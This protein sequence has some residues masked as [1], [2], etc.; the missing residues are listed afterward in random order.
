MHQLRTFGG[1]DLRDAEGREVQALLAQPKR[2]ALLVYLA[3]APA[4]NRYRRR[5]T[6]LALFWPEADTEHARASLRQALHY[7]RRSLGDQVLLGRSDEEIGID[8]NGLQCDAALLAEASRAGEWQRASALYAG[9]FL[10]GFHV[11]GAA[12]ELDEWI[13][14]ERSRLR[15]IACDA[16][17]ALAD[18]ALRVGD[19]PAA[20]RWGREG[21]RLAADPDIVAERFLRLT[22]SAQSQ[23]AA[24]VEAAVLPPQEAPAQSPDS[25]V[26]HDTGRTR[27]R[28]I[29]RAAAAMVVLV[30][31]ALVGTRVLRPPTVDS[32][33]TPPTGATIPPVKATEDTAPDAVRR[34]LP[35]DHEAHLLVLRGA[36]ALAQRTRSDFL[37]ARDFYLRA[38]ERDPV[39]ALAYM[40]LSSAYHGLAHY[41]VMAGREAMPRAR[42]AA[43][44]ALEIDSTLGHGHASLASVRAF[45]DWDYDGAEREYQVA[46]RL[47]P[48]DPESRNT[49]GVYLRVLGRFDEAT[50]QMEAA[51]RLDPLGQ[52]YLRQIGLVHFCAGKYDLALTEARRSVQ[53]D[54]RA[55]DLA[56]VLEIETLAEM[57]RFDEALDAWRL[58]TMSPLYQELGSLLGSARGEQGY[59]DVNRLK[60]RLQLDGIRR[61]SG[62]YID[63]TDMAKL[64]A[65]LGNI[66]SA[67]AWLDRAADD[68]DP[69][70][71]A[72]NCQP[73]YKPLRSDPRMQSLLRR[74]GLPSSQRR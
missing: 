21:L 4:S 54:P 15:Q 37:R 11:A 74:L 38:L 32:T 63:P 40:G 45:F 8:P 51:S 35:A 9:D 55:M 19:G 14:Q 50:R 44:R 39:Y 56:R 5:D 25:A 2:L 46:L 27:L 66:D 31:V 47:D 43:L 73:Q 26:L 65:T 60:A 36:H 1:I 68:R 7:L 62:A 57:G 52:F 71:L 69:Q 70:L 48:N 6:V 30:G 17:W 13:E 22:A 18:E 64:H 41:G 23:V 12:T 53:M 28:G 59:G 33:M 24:P 42:A 72:V 61:N 20:V 16:A 58:A 49:Y 3:L 10:E 67:F 29:W 34:S